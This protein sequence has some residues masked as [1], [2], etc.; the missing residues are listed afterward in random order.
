MIG[1]GWRRGPHGDRQSTVG[2]CTRWRRS[3]PAQLLVGLVDR[4]PQS[5]PGRQSSPPLPLASGDSGAPCASRLPLWRDAMRI[6]TGSQDQTSRKPRVPRPF[7]QRNVPRSAGEHRGERQE[8]KLHGEPTG[9]DRLL[10]RGRFGGE[11]GDQIGPH[12]RSGSCTRGDGGD[13]AGDGNGANAS[14][15]RG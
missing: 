15:A 14:P 11:L 2:C 10:V 8:E 1:D 13:R 6:C 7:A 3:R 4:P 5:E 12:Q 9:E